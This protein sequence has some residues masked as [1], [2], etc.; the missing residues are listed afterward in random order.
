MLLL[1]RK[2]IAATRARSGLSARVAGMTLAA[3]SKDPPDRLAHPGVQAHPD[4]DRHVPVHVVHYLQVVATAILAPLRVCPLSSKLRQPLHERRVRSPAELILPPLTR[5]QGLRPLCSGLRP[6]L[7]VRQQLHWGQKP[8]LLCS[9][10]Q[11]CLCTRYGRDS[12]S[13]PSLTSRC[14][15]CARSLAHWLVDRAKTLSVGFAGVVTLIGTGSAMYI[16]TKQQRGE[17]VAL[18]VDK[19]VRRVSTVLA[20]LWFESHHLHTVCGLADG[21]FDCHGVPYDNSDDHS[22][23]LRAF[24]Y[25]LSSLLRP[26]GLHE[27]WYRE[28]PE[29]LCRPAA[30]RLLQVRYAVA[31]SRF[32]AL[33]SLCRECVLRV[34]ANSFV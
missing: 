25:G 26:R 4:R 1:A 14:S 2:Q 30:L 27:R 29:Q 17:D 15:W 19:Q 31:P 6:P 5:M 23:S 8:L 12:D 11:L 9:L 21:D 28:L 33:H 10:H 16:H 34:E 32:V 18:S 7:P 20:Q 22:H 3:G 13:A 24:S